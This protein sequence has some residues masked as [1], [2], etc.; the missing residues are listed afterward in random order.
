MTTSITPIESCSLVGTQEHKLIIKSDDIK[1]LRSN[2]I[3]S[4]QY[5]GITKLGLCTF[6][7][8]SEY[9]G[10]NNSLTGDLVKDRLLKVCC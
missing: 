6:T 9:N 5:M 7:G 3:I 8:F 1:Y 2:S 10:L 4:I